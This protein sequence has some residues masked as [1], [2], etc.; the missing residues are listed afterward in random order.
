MGLDYGNVSGST[1]TKI[2]AAQ[3]HYDASGNVVSIGYCLNPT[4]ANPTYTEYFYLRNGQGDITTIIDRTGKK[5]TS[6]AYDNWGKVTVTDHGGGSAFAKLA[7][8]CYRGYLYDADSQLYY[9]QSRFYDPAIGRF[10]SPDAFLSMR[11]YAKPLK[12][13]LEHLSCVCG[14]VDGTIGGYIFCTLPD[15]A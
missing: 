3:F 13:S 11:G 1:Y 14:T 6:Y 9:C 2:R 7:S 5:L 15:K 8:F 12:I 10:I 4:A